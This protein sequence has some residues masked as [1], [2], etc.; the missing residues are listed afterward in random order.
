MTR[1]LGYFVRGCLVLMPVGLTL[2]AIYWLVHGLDEL[3]GVTMPGLGIAIALALITAVGV[4]FSN[5]VGRKLSSWI[6]QSFARLPLVKVLYTS[7]RDLLNAFLG[8][9]RRF[10]Q[11]VA[12]RLSAD[13]ETRLFGFM[14]RRELEMFALRDHVAIYVPQAYNIGGQVIGVPRHLIEPLDVK[15]A[16]MLTFVVSGG[17]S[18][19]RDRT[20][21]PA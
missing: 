21:R 10:G 18:G 6:D 1:L 7:I 15:P 8:E 16:D 17:A 9:E 14:T 2:Y 11:A 3:L 5:V 20:S 4:L 12:F 19:F 13:S